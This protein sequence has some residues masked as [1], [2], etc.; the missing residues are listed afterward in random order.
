ML[1]TEKTLAT[2]FLARTDTRGVSVSDRRHS[3]WW[4]KSPDPRGNQDLGGQ[5]SS[6][7]NDFYP[8]GEQ[9]SVVCGVEPMSIQ[10]ICH[11]GGV[12][13]KQILFEE[14][15]RQVASPKQEFFF[16]TYQS[17]GNASGPK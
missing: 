10:V 6:R 14:G 11:S 5:P 17:T 3:G 15:V 12:L 4:E 16:P 1:G 8:I 9:E 7:I 13:L 2:D